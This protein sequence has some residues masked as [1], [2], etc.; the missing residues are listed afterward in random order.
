MKLATAVTLL[1]TGVAVGVFV[2]THPGWTAWQMTKFL[3]S[4]CLTLYVGVWMNSQILLPILFNLP[5]SIWHFVTG[6]LRFA[7]VLV[8]FI[9]PVSWLLLS[10][11][12]GFVAPSFADFLSTSIGVVLGMTLSTLVVLLS[13]VTPSGLRDLRSDYDEN[14]FARFRQVGFDVDRILRSPRD[15]LIDPGRQKQSREL[16]AA[17]EA[18]MR[19]KEAQGLP[20]K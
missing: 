7:G 3:A 16:L 20:L 17:R 8:Q 2:D 12:I 19:E 4:F 18:R 14:T 13:L 15:R 9:A 1:G 11:I 5:K 10:A 6:K